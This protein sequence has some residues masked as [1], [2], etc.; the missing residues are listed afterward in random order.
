M[1]TNMYCCT[2]VLLAVHKSRHYTPPPPP[3]PPPASPQLASRWAVLMRP[4]FSLS[5]GLLFPGTTGGEVGPRGDLMAGYTGSEP[6]GGA[7]DG[8][9]QRKHT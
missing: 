1:H 3:P 8:T 7:G 6:G 5:V 2:V 9:R 4:R